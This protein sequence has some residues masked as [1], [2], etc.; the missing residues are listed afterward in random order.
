MKPTHPQTLSLTA[1]LYLIS[2]YKV[3][4]Q[5]RE[6]SW[7]RVRDSHHSLTQLWA[8]TQVDCRNLGP[9]NGPWFTAQ[10]SLT[11]FS[12]I[13]TTIVAT[14]AVIYSKHY[15]IIR[16]SQ[17]SLTKFSLVTETIITTSGFILFQKVPKKSM[18]HL[19]SALWMPGKGQLLD[20]MIQTPRLD[21]DFVLFNSSNLLL[22][23]QQ[24]IVQTYSTAYN[25]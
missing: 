22:H 9:R 23:S 6:L 15:Q 1:Y 17:H 16:D 10:Q 21:S 12:T 19:Q 3:N 4:R 25:T 8:V 18:I 7:E 20:L 2:C 5:N 11:S 14:Q 13:I 24:T